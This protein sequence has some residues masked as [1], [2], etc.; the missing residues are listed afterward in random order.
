L[1][2]TR[3]LVAWTRTM[4]RLDTLEALA[5]VP[6]GGRRL[7]PTEV[8]DYLRSLPTLWAD[9]GTAGR[10]TMVSAIFAQ[11][12]VPEF[13]RLEYEL[14]P[15]AIALGLDAALPSVMEAKGQTC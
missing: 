14:S 9:S 7:S 13:K 8:V 4:A 10:Q 1:A 6:L 12:D 5:Q 3:D 15:D 11:L 2:K